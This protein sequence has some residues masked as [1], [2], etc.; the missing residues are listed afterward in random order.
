MAKERSP[1]Q[2]KAAVKYYIGKR[3]KDQL[4]HLTS[5]IEAIRVALDVEPG[6]DLA[7]I[8]RLYRNV[9]GAIAGGSVAPADARR[10]A[11]KAIFDPTSLRAIS[12]DRSKIEPDHAI[13]DDSHNLADNMPAGQGR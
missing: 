5:R 12:R 7:V 11:N 9:L 4:A 3:Q 8:A 1:K 2:R 10:I 6:V 13:E